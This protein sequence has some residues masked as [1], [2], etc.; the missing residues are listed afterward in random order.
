MANSKDHVKR[1]REETGAGVMDCK[2]AL[3][4]AKGDFEKAKS[5]IKERGLA[6]AKEKA[7]REANEGVVEAYIHAGGR[8]GAMVEL[9]SET[10]FVARNSDFKELAR[11]IAMQVAAM[12]P[13]DVDQLL[14][15]P[16]IRDA[17]KTIGELVTGI[18]STTGEN[19]RVRRFKRFELGQSN[20][21]PT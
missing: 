12:N 1:L 14:G 7:D 9:S 17:S 4:E 16:Y 8:I 2:R 10:D 19:V 11:E 18:A 21:E 15:Q 20:G 5:L 3:D 13:T 6:K